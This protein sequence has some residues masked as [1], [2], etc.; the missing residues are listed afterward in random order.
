MKYTPSAKFNE[1]LDVG[2]RA[3]NYFPHCV[4]STK[5]MYF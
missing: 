3:Y 4:S 2:V 5:D 1:Q